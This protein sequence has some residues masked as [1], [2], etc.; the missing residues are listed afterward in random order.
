M[1]RNMESKKMTAIKALSYRALVTSILL[2]LLDFYFRHRPNYSHYCCLCC[3]C[4]IRVLWTRKGLA[5]SQMANEEE[6]WHKSPLPSSLKTSYL[7]WNWHIGIWAS[8]SLQ[9][10]F[11]MLSSCVDWTIVSIVGSFCSHIRKWYN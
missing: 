6:G 9:R 10:L 1:N 5:Q 11:P 2:V 8:C 3:P 4:N 7:H